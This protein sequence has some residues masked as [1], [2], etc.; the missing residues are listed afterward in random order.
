[1]SGLDLHY[2]TPGEGW[3]MF[4]SLTAQAIDLPISKLAVDKNVAEVIKGELKNF[5][6]IQIRIQLLLKGYTQ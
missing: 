6:K 2:V 4:D 3:A 5:V 1:M